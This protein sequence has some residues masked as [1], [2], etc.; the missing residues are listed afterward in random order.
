MERLFFGVVGLA[1]PHAKPALGK[2]LLDMGRLDGAHTSMSSA[3]SVAVGVQVGSRVGVHAVVAN[4]T[5]DADELPVA[6]DKHERGSAI[7]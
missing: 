6:R 3:A 1:Y 5:P 7:W 2:P 4:P